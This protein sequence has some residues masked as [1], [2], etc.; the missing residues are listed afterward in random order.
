[1]ASSSSSS[2]SWMPVQGTHQVNIGSSLRRA[3][4]ARKNKG[5]PPAPAPSAKRLPERDFY[6]FRYN[7]KPTSID[8]EKP[9]SIDVRK[10]TDSTAITVEYPSKQ[11]GESHVFKGTENVA[12]EW[13]CVLVYDE[14]LGTFA[15]EK[16]DSHAV[17]THERKPVAARLH[18]PPVQSSSQ[19]KAP[20][21]QDD[22]EAQLEKDL[23]D[24]ANPDVGHGGFKEMIPKSI[25]YRQEEEEDPVEQVT[26]AP[27]PV[28]P[29]EPPQ[30]QRPAN[31]PPL[32][33][34]TQRA[35]KPSAAKG[36]GK[37]VAQPPMAAAPVPKLPPA[38][39]PLVGRSAFMPPPTKS[40]PA[41]P[42][43]RPKP[44]PPSVSVSASSSSHTKL[45]R[46]R[47]PEPVTHLSDADA[48]EE[49]LEFGKPAKKQARKAAVPAPLPSVPQPV[50]GGLA[51]P[52]TS[53]SVVQPPPVSSA[54]KTSTSA[55]AST[56][57]SFSHRPLMASTTN[58]GGGISA[59]HT[60]A[61]TIPE[62]GESDSEG[63]WYEVEL[64]EVQED[65]IFGD[66]NAT[67][68]G[69]GEED[70]AEQ[71]GED[72]DMDEFEEQMN[73]QMEEMEEP[74]EDSVFEPELDL[75]EPR[76]PPMSLN[77]YARGVTGLSDD[78]TSSSED[79]DD[80]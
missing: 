27:A 6:A 38:P 57:S 66:A 30:R 2:S 62:G 40:K 54:P 28:Q 75:G 11:K 14:E 45:P 55:S 31:K 29:P 49:V 74:Y 64:E 77:D 23:L 80:D 52:G 58:T 63:E 25:V 15:L 72:I 53:S 46:K 33:Q 68:G 48:D 32:K 47:E 17:L 69:Y 78:D 8:S 41:P 36:K 4:K 76:G 12:K 20:P 43:P 37:A 26:R 71:G 65:D 61:P 24:L 67:G 60:S 16:L 44:Q 5:Q 79:S 21:P 19:T 18:A 73:Q 22:L 13:D 7:F 56:S 1:M 59:R 39:P 34:Q 51:L 10:T 42:S 3:L 9:G 70:E 50:S 35:V